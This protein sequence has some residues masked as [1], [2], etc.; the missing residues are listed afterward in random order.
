MKIEQNNQIP[1]LDALLIHNVKQLVKLFMVMQL[2][3]TFILTGNLLLLINES[4]GL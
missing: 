1:F 2:I 3:E 4:A